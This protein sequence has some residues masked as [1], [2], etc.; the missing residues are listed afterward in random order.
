M[1][2]LP[3]R[4][5]LDHLRRQARDLLR[6]AQAGDTAAAGPHPGGVRTTDP[7]RRAA[8]GGPRIRLRQLAPAEGRGRRPHARA[9]PAQADAFCEASIR[10]GTGRAARMLAATPRAR[11]LQLRHRGDAGRRRPRADRARARP[12]AGDPGRPANGLDGAARGVRV[13]LA[14]ARPGPGRRAAGRGPAA[15]RRRRRPD[16]APA[17]AAQRAGWTPLRCAV[18]GAAN[19][20][21]TELLLERGAVPGDHD[22]YLAGFADDDHECLRLLLG[23]APPI[24]PELAAHGARRPDQHRRHRGRPAAAG[25]RGR[26]EP[27]AAARRRRPAVARV[28]AAVQSGCSAELVGLLLG[29]GADPDAAGPTAARP[30]GWPSAGPDRPGRPAAAPPRRATTPPTPTGSSPPACAPTAPAPERQLAAIP[31]CPAD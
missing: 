25:G 26:P 2:D 22:L 14:P 7:G 24:S 11:R 9:W 28:Y 18:A 4:P 20:L 6:A 29:H 27:A 30:T 8:R 21:I 12:G 13:A 15:A 19:P 31:G 5:S 3:A 1:A 16:G 17:R 23:H 10:D